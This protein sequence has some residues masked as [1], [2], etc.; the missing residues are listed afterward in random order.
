MEIKLSELLSLY[1]Q[2]DVDNFIKSL[3]INNLN[4]KNL[5]YEKI[6]TNWRFLGNNSSN[7][8]SI[9]SLKEGPKGLIERITNAVDAVIEKYK[10]KLNLKPKDTSEI[11]KKA[12][13][14]YYSL[15]NSTNITKLYAKDAEDKVF[16]VVNDGSKSNKPTFDVIDLGIGINGE[17]FENTILSIA[18]GNKFSADKNYLIGAFGQG[19]S[20]SLPF[21]TSTIILSKYDSKFYF[22]IIKY[23]ELSD[24]RIGA[25]VYL[26]KDNKIM[27]IH[28]DIDQ[29]NNKW[30]KKFITSDSGTFIRMIETDIP[31]KYRENEVTKPG[32]LLSYIDTQLFNVKFPIKI[33]DNRKNF[34]SNEASQNRYSYGSYLHLCSTKKHVKKEYSGTIKIEYKGILYDIE[35]FAVLPNDENKWGIEIECKKIFEQ[36]NIFGD[37]IIYTINGQTINSEK[38]TKLSNAGLNFLKYRLLVIINLDKLG[39]EKYKFVTSNRQDI[40]T[41]DLTKGFLEKI[42]SQLSNTDLLKELNQK[43]GDMMLSTPVDA[44]FLSELKKEVKNK[45]IK[46]L[47]NIKEIPSHRVKG[48]HNNESDEEIFSDTIE[49]LEIT[50]QKNVFYKDQSINFILTTRAQK[51]INLNAKIYMYI[52]DKNFYDFTMNSMNGRISYTI[53]PGKISV[54]WHNIKFCYFDE[55]NSKNNKESNCKTFNILD[56]KSPTNINREYKKDLDI[57]IQTLKGQ[58]LIL[59]II[60]NLESKKLIVQLCLDHDMLKNDLYQRYSEDQVKKNQQKL[61]VPLSYFGLF[62]EDEYNK[63]DSDDE[64]NQLIFNIIKAI[65]LTSNEEN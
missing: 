54:G 26:T 36:Y 65:V 3:S 27:E 16:L 38:F 5:S 64:K 40:R 6:K 55:K 15:I 29:C 44:E 60:K 37:P 48:R 22:T 20:T 53:D 7:S 62:H 18:K 46:Y 19:G 34:I 52:D 57:D 8:S 21:A 2:N 32:M 11:I 12:F 13:P 61:C 1:K 24:Y 43:I 42:I 30:I 33:I 51:H 56:T 31:K 14:N 50:S 49:I 35:Y 23:V 10:Q 63:I 4:D 9:N 41:T 45:Y 25:Y 28:N 47:K 58:Y 59:N 39:K 17:N